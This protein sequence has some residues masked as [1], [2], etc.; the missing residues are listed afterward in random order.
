MHVE[1]YRDNPPRYAT[2]PRP[3]GEV[4]A[5]LHELLVTERLLDEG[6]ALGAV[7]Q[8][9]LLTS[10]KAT[11][12][13]DT[14]VSTFVHILAQRVKHGDVAGANDICD[15]QRECLAEFRAPVTLGDDAERMWL[16]RGTRAPYDSYSYVLGVMG[17]LAVREQLRAGELTPDEY[18][19]FLE[20][21]G[22]KSSVELFKLLGCDVTTPD[23]FERAT[24]AF[25]SYVNRM[26]T[27]S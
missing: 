22:C 19:G 10:L 2:C 12:Y 13:R 3:V 20:A 1:H 21:T 5:V 16:G 24:G 14:M 17:A 26:Y 25:D 4:P 8:S 18:R 27:E 15:V 6:G 11:L 23:P 7:A 9:Q